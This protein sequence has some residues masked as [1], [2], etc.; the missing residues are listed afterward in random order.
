MISGELFHCT[1]KPSLLRPGDTSGSGQGIVGVGVGGGTGVCEGVTVGVSVG[2]A[3]AWPL[4][5]G[6]K[7]L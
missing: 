4:M 7:R 2:R 5:P 6:R 1:C 3:D